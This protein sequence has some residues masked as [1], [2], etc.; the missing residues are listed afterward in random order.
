MVIG[1]LNILDE[2]S[3]STKANKGEYANIHYL[4]PL[5]HDMCGCR[6]LMII[7]HYKRHVQR[8]S[9]RASQRPESY[10]GSKS[11]WGMGPQKRYERSPCRRE[12]TKCTLESIRSLRLGL[13]ATYTEVKKAGTPGPTKLMNVGKFPF[14]PGFPVTILIL[15][16]NS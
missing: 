6:H 1:P 15:K 16:Q 4:E 9:F 10:R 11:Y 3:L 5:N 12:S 7:R 14:K 8:T 2:K 13:E